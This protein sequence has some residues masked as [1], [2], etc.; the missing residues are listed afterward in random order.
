MGKRTLSIQ[1]NDIGDDTMGRLVWSAALIAAATL[2]SG[3]AS[4]EVANLEKKQITIAVGGVASQI[5]KLP[6]AIA[7]NKGFFKQEGLEVD[8][9]V[10]GSGAK[11]LQALV[12]GQADATQGAYEHT[13]RMQ[14][15]GFD[16]TC[17]GMFARYPGNVL[18]AVK[19]TAS[20]IKSP[21]DLKGKKIGVSSPGSASHNFVAQ[22]MQRAGVNHKD[23]SI[24]GIGIGPSA[25]AAVQ[26]G[27]E[28]DALVNLDPAITEL[29]NS[30]SAVVLVDSRNKEGSEQAFGGDYL[31]GCV[32]VK[33]EFV[34][35]NP[36]TAQAISDGIIHAMQWLKTASID[37][38]IASL[39]PEY[40]RANE[41]AYR[42]ALQKNMSSFTWD[43]L[44]T[45]AAARNVLESISVLEPALKD[46]SKI[47][48]AKT[49][50]N[51][52]TKR[53]LAKYAKTPSQ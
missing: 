18:M 1:N 12:G 28:L 53:S 29:E 48:L 6:Y 52:I 41:A 16:L 27:N 35:Q 26:T 17:L 38:V 13:I 39:P 31:A 4:A 49:Y 51:E 47:D 32:Y 9:V 30:G 36:K 15:K 11:G 21:A 45:E 7:L 3:A 46:D 19:R 37:D 20:E 5:D 34:K 25:V 42:Q 8:S 14:T 43:G 10:F 33:S 44:V 24:I 50:N 40:Y 2:H 23:A 22:L